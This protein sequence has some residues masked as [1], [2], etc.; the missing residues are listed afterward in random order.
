[1]KDY[2]KFLK[3][4]KRL[5]PIIQSILFLGRQN[6]PFRGHREEGNILDDSVSS[7]N[8]GNFCELL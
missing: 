6:I 7:V 1:M 8:M 5:I 4:E 3:I 2:F